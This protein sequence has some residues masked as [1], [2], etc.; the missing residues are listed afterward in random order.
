MKYKHELHLK[1]FVESLRN[2]WFMSENQM[3][4]INI[5]VTLKNPPKLTAVETYVGPC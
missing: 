5:Y 4:F 1:S 3:S 2:Q